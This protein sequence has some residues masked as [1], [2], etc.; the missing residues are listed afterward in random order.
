MSYHCLLIF[1]KPSPPPVQ[2]QHSNFSSSAPRTEVHTVHEK[3]ILR[4]GQYEYNSFDEVLVWV[5]KY[6]ERHGVTSM[7]DILVS[8][9]HFLNIN[10]IQAAELKYPRFGEE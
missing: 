10:N 8:R 3:D 4:K 1:Q 7:D 9:D 5:N 6:E 2:D